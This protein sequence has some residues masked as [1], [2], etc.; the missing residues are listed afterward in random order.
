MYIFNVDKTAVFL[1]MCGRE[2]WGTWGT[3]PH[4]ALAQ[5][6][7]FKWACRTAQ[8]EFRIFFKG[9]KRQKNT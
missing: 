8:N 5:K 7:E 2:K 4:H 3:Q 6:I 1:G 9:E